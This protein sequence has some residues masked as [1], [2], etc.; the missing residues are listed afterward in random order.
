MCKYEE[1][2]FTIMFGLMT[3][4]IVLIIVVGIWGL[5]GGFDEIPAGYH[6]HH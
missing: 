6:I 2:F 4:L 1:L 5:A 3:I